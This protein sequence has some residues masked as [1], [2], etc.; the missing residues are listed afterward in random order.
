MVGTFAQFISRR[1]DHI[2]Y[3]VGDPRSPGQSR[4]AG[5][6]GLGLRPLPEIAMVAGLTKRL[7][8]NEQPRTYEKS[9]FDRRLEVPIGA[10]GIAQSGEA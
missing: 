4:T 3:A 6:E 1:L 7:T 9:L 10:S 2:R 8:G 5:A